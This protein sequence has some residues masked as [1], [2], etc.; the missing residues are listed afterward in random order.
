MKLKKTEE[1]KVV[2]SLL[3]H[4]GEFDGHFV[5]GNAQ[6]E[7]TTYM[8]HNAEK[9]FLPSLWPYLSIAGRLTC[10]H[11]FNEKY[12][13]Q[14][15]R[16]PY[17]INYVS[18]ENLNFLFF[19]DKG[20]VY[21]NL[22]LLKYANSITV[23][24]DYLTIDYLLKCEKLL[25]NKQIKNALDL[26]TIDELYAAFYPVESLNILYN[27]NANDLSCIK[28]ESRY[29][30]IPILSHQQTQFELKC[31]EEA[32]EIIDNASGYV[33]GA[34]YLWDKV[35]AFEDNYIKVCRNLTAEFYEKNSGYTMD[36]IFLFNLYDSQPKE[37]KAKMNSIEFVKHFLFR[38][39]KQKDAEEEKSM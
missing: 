11:W 10:L 33:G 9:A 12:S 29:S 16:E 1:D 38:N 21:L 22:E 19:T 24:T 14:K 6:A 35:K 18:D 27:F 39:E 4:L 26:N 23:L 25:C 7:I 31:H 5:N 37:V 20:N 3:I 13:K 2:S 36:A 28:E 30:L 15:G 32:L 34:V 17:K 8:P